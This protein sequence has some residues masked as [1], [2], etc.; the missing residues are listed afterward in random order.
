MI[1]PRRHSAWLALAAFLCSFVLPAFGV[2][3]QLSGDDAACVSAQASE[4]G[5]SL[6]RAAAPAD[7]DHCPLCHFQRAV[8]GASPVALTR[9]FAPAGSSLNVL[10]HLD[11]GHTQVLQTR[12]SRAPP[13]TL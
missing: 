12:A 5:A 13:S 11:F 8:G 9:L 3:H 2:D 1:R 6:T 10:A 7:A 4:A